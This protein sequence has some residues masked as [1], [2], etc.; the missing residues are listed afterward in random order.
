MMQQPTA[1]PPPP[2]DTLLAPSSPLSHPSFNP[3][4]PTLLSPSLPSPSPLSPSPSSPPLLP[5]RPPLHASIKQQIEYYLSIINLY[6]PLIAPYRP[7]LSPAAQTAALAASQSPSSSPSLLLSDSELMQLSALLHPSSAPPSPAP[8]SAPPQASQPLS[9]SGAFIQSLSELP[10]HRRSRVQGEECAICQELLIP[11]ASA[12][13]E[14]SA[15]SPTAVSPPCATDSPVP[16]FTLSAASPSRSPSPPLSPSSSS[17]SCCLPP[18]VLQLPCDHLFHEPC[19]VR[20][21]LRHNSCPCC[22]RLLPTDDPA[23]NLAVV[24][25]QPPPLKRKFSADNLFAAQ[26]QQ[27]APQLKLRRGSKRRRLASA[28]GPVPACALS[29]EGVDCVL[30]PEGVGAIP[31]AATMERLRCGHCFHRQCLV[32]AGQL[33]GCDTKV[34]RVRLSA[35]ETAEVAEPSARAPLVFCP[36]CRTMTAHAS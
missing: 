6:A 3:M 10:L 17:S 21:L 8:A 1:S 19:V 35:A 11:A 15:L 32:T 24:C 12:Q 23:Y 30:L 7:Q 36:L 16:A 9:T 5:S 31:G 20:W 28:A 18:R 27:T 14:R 2:L 34:K 29:A 25:T 22:R 26:Q 13:T 4:P 33:M